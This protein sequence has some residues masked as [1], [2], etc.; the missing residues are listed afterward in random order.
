[1]QPPV[2]SGAP[3]PYSKTH[4]H[5]GTLAAIPPCLPPLPP[6]PPQELELALHITRLPEALEDA[7]E[8]LTLNRWGAGCAG[9]LYWRAGKGSMWVHVQ[10]DGGGNGG[11]CTGAVC[12]P[13]QGWSATA[14]ACLLHAL[15]QL[16]FRLVTLLPRVTEYL[17]DLSEKFNAFYVDCKVL[18]SEQEAS[19]LLLC[20][21]TAV[22]M[23]KC[24]ELL[25][26]KPLYRI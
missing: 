11:W 21:A 19:R 16:T 25:G 12:L 3:V 22:V 9:A 8:E 24:F 26:I 15:Q 13:G 5:A 7:I 14:D 17:Y 23:R 10:P 6:L 20:E 2:P 18:G 4:P 1:M